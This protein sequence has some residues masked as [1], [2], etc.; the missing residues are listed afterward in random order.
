MIGGLGDLGLFHIQTGYIV[1]FLFSRQ[2]YKS[3]LGLNVLYMKSTYQLTIS[4]LL[5]VPASLG[6]VLTTAWLGKITCS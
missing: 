2:N 3:T 6:C 5:C 1:S 4:L